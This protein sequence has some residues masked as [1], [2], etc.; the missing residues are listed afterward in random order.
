MNYW[1]Q[2]AENIYVAAHRGWC[3]KY[4][5]NT[6][7]AIR[8]AGELGVDQIEVDIRVTRDGELVLIHDDTVDRTTNGTGRVCDYTFE[9]LRKL[10]AG[11]RFGRG[12]HAGAIIPTLDELMEYASALPAMT[13]DLELKVYP[14]EGNEE[15]AYS[16][17]DRVIAKVEE[18]GFADRVVL[19]SFSALLHEYILKKYGDRY[20]QHVYFPERHN[21]GATISPYSYAY[22]VCMF[23]DNY[24]MASPEEFAK[25][26]ESGVRTWAGAGVRDAEGVDM[27]IKCGAE[28]ITCN[29]PDVILSL[30]RQRGRHA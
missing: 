26:R 28:L 18:Y 19:N 14:S 7:E 3:A 30:L 5:E 23:G 21:H 12:E 10:D 13:L 6:M 20:L 2:S 15:L 4:P 22:C 1:T 27:A 25:M 24:G 29:N 16:V 8:A 9:E 11:Y 17:C